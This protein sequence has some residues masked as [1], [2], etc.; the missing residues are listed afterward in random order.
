M[1]KRTKREL[2]RAGVQVGVEASTEL[3]RA[4]VSRIA[5]WIGGS[6]KGRGQT[7]SEARKRK[8]ERDE[9]DAGS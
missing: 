9:R 3:I 4:I 5:G 7:L 6:R 1:K 8:E 2:G